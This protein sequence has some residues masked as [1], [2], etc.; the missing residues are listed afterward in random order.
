MHI[1]EGYLPLLWC[2]FWYLVSIPFIFFGVL[3]IKKIFDQHPEQKM[4]LAVSGAFI[5][6]LSS[7]KIPS[8]TGS[9]SHPTGTGISSILFGP[10]V[11]AV[12]ST[13]V[14]IFQA[15][16]LAHGGFTTLGAN[17]FSMGIAGPI[18]GWLAFKAMRSFK[19]GI[20]PSVFIAIVLADWITYVTTSFELAIA[21]PGANILNTFL[22]F[23]GIF[24]LTQIPLAIGEGILLTIFFDFMMSNRPRM[25]ASLLKEKALVNKEETKAVVQ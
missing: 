1:M 4:I 9:S 23:M 16:L 7:L 19:A 24:A 17:V 13:I 22:S 11:T 15:T 25:I 21:Y 18:A 3:Q 10:A 12:I 6:V 5:F 8:V 14:L 2:I 20:L